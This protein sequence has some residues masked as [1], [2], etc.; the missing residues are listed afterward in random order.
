MAPLWINCNLRVTQ[1]HQLSCPVHLLFAASKVLKFIYFYLQS[2]IIFSTVWHIHTFHKFIMVAIGWRLQNQKARVLF[3]SALVFAKLDKTPN[4]IFVVSPQIDYFSQLFS[5]FS[6]SPQLA[7]TLYLM[8]TRT[9]AGQKTPK[10]MMRI[11]LHYFQ[12]L[13][14]VAFFAVTFVRSST[15]DLLGW[16]WRFPIL[17]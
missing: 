9:T 11:M 5:S 15:I 7:Q 17:N 8:S 13:V 16:K 2:I 10:T 6:S 3:Y 1:A 4:W 14:R 12:P